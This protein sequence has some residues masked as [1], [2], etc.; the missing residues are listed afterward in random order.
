MSFDGTFT[1]ALTFSFDDG[2]VDDIRLVELLKKYKLKATF[3]L[4]S[5]SLA[6]PCNW[7]FNKQKEVR[8]IRF[9]EHPNL[10]DGYEVA[11]HTLNHPHLEE[12]PYEG[13]KFEIQADKEQLE[14]LYG[15]DICG[16][17]L[18]FGTYD[19][20]VIEI[21]SELEILYCRTIDSTY[22]FT[23][24]DELPLLHPTCHFKSENL[25]DLADKF[26]NSDSEE[27]MLFYIWGHSYELVSEQ[28]WQRFEKFCSKISNRSDVYYCTNKEAIVNYER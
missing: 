4:N 14:K 7:I 1:K 2:N 21:V 15:Y 10:Y 26:L 28:D 19:E 18:P 11:G 16:L 6:N 9:L 8:R 27:N 3:N 12:L 20:E 17:A 25:F 5:S 24:P 13:K 23:V 22:T